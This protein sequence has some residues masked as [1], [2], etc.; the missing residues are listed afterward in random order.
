[1]NE[2]VCPHDRKGLRVELKNGTVLAMCADCAGE[3]ITYRAS[4]TARVIRN[5]CD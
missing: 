2:P 4:E 3:Q 1:M 5:G